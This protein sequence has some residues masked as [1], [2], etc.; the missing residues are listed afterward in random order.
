MFKE[1]EQLINSLGFK[2][3]SQ[4]FDRPWGGFL[5]IDE[6]QAQEFSNHF[7]DGLHVETLKIGGKLSP[8]ILI[9]KPESRLS[10]Q[11]HNRRAEIWQIFQGS[12]GIVRSDNDTETEMKVHDEGDQIVLKQGERH[13][14]IGLDNHCVVAEIWQ[15]TDKNNPSDEDDIIR[16]QDDFGR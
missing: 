8:K 11:Y 12:A 16:V 10:W 14:L 7:F 5:V 2:I 1:S 4:D 9:V 13:R 6:T 15:H 3:T